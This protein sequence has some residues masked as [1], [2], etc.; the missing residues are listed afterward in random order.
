[1]LFIRVTVLLKC[2]DLFDYIVMRRDVSEL[3]VYYVHIMVHMVI[4]IWMP[5]GGAVHSAEI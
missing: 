5:D 2:F 4:D 1:M 3:S